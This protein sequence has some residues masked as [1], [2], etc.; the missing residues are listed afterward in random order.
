MAE[1][2]S[3]LIQ[4]GSSDPLLAQAADNLLLVSA[5]RRRQSAGCRCGPGGEKMPRD[6]YQQP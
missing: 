1:S 2:S 5:K 4:S 3:G 6:K